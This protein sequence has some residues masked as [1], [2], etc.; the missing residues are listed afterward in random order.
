MKKVFYSLSLLSVF[1][2]MQ[3]CDKN[4]HHPN[5]SAAIVIDTTLVSNTEYILNLKPYGDA[6]DVATIKKQA[7]T[8]TTSEIVN[9]SSQ[10]NP[11]YHF[12]ANAKEMGTQQVVL[13]VTEGNH[14]NG[15]SNYHNDSTLIT[16][17]F[18]IKP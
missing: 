1:T 12:I 16:I 9:N 13:A 14:G 10:F 7:T 17:N 8:F 15:S 4:M 2:I 11:V 3:S 5:T 18:T 6:D